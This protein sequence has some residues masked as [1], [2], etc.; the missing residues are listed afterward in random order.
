LRLF[1]LYF[2]SVNMTVKQL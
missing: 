1:E 2:L